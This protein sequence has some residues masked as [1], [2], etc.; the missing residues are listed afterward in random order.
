MDIKT[1]WASGCNCELSTMELGHSSCANYANADAHL[2]LLN[3]YQHDRSG[4]G[5]DEYSRD[6]S[7][8]I[9]FVEV[10]D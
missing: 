1:A 6:V 7:G 2:L 3:A 10:E 8:L 5:E 9:G 4:T